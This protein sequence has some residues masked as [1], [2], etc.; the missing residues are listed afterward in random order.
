MMCQFLE[1][2]KVFVFWGALSWF[3]FGVVFVFDPFAVLS[4]DAIQLWHHS[5]SKK[6]QS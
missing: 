4:I 6:N 1:E 5:N 2:S 3:V